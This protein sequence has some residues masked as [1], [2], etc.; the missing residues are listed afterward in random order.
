MRSNRSADNLF[1]NISLVSAADNHQNLLCLHNG[2]DAHSISLLRNIID[3]GEETLVCFNGAGLQIYTVSQSSEGVIRLVKS[4]M[5]IVAKAQKLKI[6]AA[7]LFDDLIVASALFI[8]VRFGSIR[9]IGA[10]QV[11]IYMLEQIIV[12]E[13]VVALIIV[14]GQTLVFI[15]VYSRNTGK[16]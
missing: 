8:A 5:S 2:L 6:Y 13:I 14:S 7:D 15:Q 4:D 9:N 11:D 3:A 12:H 10:G 1:Q 16:I